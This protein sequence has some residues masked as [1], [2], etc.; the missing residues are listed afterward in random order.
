[1]VT[2]QYTWEQQTRQMVRQVADRALE[3]R[4]RHPPHYPSKSRSGRG[5]SWKILSQIL[6]FEG[7]LSAGRLSV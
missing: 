4:E 5:L 3:R 6:V 1:M 7:V 2:E